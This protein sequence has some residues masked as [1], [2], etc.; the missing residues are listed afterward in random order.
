MRR[1]SLLKALVTVLMVLTVISASFVP[2]YAAKGVYTVADGTETVRVGEIPNEPGKDTNDSI[3]VVNL[4]SSVR[5]IENGAF[6]NCP[7][8]RIMNVDGRRN[9]VNFDPKYVFYTI[10]GL[11][12]NYDTPPMDSVPAEYTTQSA[13]ATTT[14]TKAPE[15]TTAAPET[16][17]DS[18]TTTTTE[19]DTTTTTTTEAYSTVDSWDELISG[20]VAEDTSVE[21]PSVL[22]KVLPF[23]GAGAA[24]IGAIVLMVLKFKK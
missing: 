2:A 9:S 23:V 19:A 20:D 15:T 12:V 14:T 7:N 1:S 8:I 16:T 4:P 18:S 21:R 13:D 24:L 17:T 6:K 22:A 5:N 10:H 3:I 11:K